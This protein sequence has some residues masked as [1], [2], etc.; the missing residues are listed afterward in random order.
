LLSWQFEQFDVMPLWIIAV[1]GAGFANALPG[2]E[3]VAL[4]GTSPA[5]V[6]GKWQVSQAVPDGMCDVG[7]IGEVAGITTIFEMP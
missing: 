7:P 4:P 1:V 3:A 2:T 6:E 5:G